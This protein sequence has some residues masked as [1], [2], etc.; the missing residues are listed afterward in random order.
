MV[1]EA[2]VEEEKARS[3]KMEAE[4]QAKAAAA[5]AAAAEA[6]A[7]ASAAEKEKKEKEA[8]EAAAEA[9][10]AAAAAADAEAS[11]AATK[12][13]SMNLGD[14]DKVDEVSVGSTSYRRHAE[15]DTASHFI[16]APRK[17]AARSRDVSRDAARGRE[18][19]MA[20]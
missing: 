9:A 19:R 3:A 12:L 18:G 15:V 17:K 4:K 20:G 10:A 6:E 1:R 5:A 11:S 2:N 16:V 7:A 13:S 8:A 14:T